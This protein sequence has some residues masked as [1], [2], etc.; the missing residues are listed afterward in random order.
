M[1]HLAILTEALK[2]ERK[3][4]EEDEYL[5]KKKKGIVDFRSTQEIRARIKGQDGIKRTE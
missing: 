1:T 2:D 4:E 5:R 3:Q